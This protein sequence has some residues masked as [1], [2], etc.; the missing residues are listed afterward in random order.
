MLIMSVMAI[1]VALKKPLCIDS[2][3]VHRIDRVSKAQTESTFSCSQFKIEKFSPYFS[4]N[5]ESLNRRLGSVSVQLTG[6]GVIKPIRVEILQNKSQ[7]HK[8]SASS[9][10]M[11]EDL[12]ASKE[13]ES[14]VMQAILL[15]KTKS[16]DESS[17]KMISDYLM[18]VEAKNDYIADLWRRSLD[19]LNAVQKIQMKLSVQKSLGQLSKFKTDSSLENIIQFILGQPKNEKFKQAFYENIHNA[20]LVGENSQ[21]DLLIQLQDIS[22]IDLKQL[23]TQTKVNFKKIALQTDNGIY[24]LPYMVPLN[25]KLASNIKAQMRLVIS[26]VSTEDK[27]LNSFIQNTEHLILVSSKSSQNLRNL[28][29]SQLL[30]DWKEFI[31]HHPKIQFVKFHIPSLRYIS[32]K[33]PQN[34]KLRQLMSEAS[35]Q[36]IGQ[37]NLGW[38]QVNWDLGLKAYQPVAFY[39]AVQSY[40]LN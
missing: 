7:H 25:E 22:Q 17:I 36:Q 29:Y 9:V 6:I 24:V 31:S 18:G 28:N 16:A 19:N 13:F 12:L 20:Q 33:A 1:E 38:K 40:R 14:L 27:T 5:Q 11:S 8:V 32:K 10:I 2:S 4:V 23:Q 37:N 3:I 21:F 34:F 26:S 30:T 39:D 15:Q 35:V